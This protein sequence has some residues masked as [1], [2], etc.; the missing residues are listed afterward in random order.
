MH[1]LVLCDDY[2]RPA[3]VPREGLGALNESEFTFEE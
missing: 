3:R 1:T 2:W